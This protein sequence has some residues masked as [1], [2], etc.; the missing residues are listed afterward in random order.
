MLGVIEDAGRDADADAD[1]AGAERDPGPPWTRTPAGA[2]ASGLAASRFDRALCTCASAALLGNL[3]SSAAQ[4]GDASIGIGGALQAS[5]LAGPID[6]DLI[7]TGAAASVIAANAAEI[8][9]DLEVRGDLAATGTL[10]VSGDARFGGVLSGDGV[11]TVQGDLQRPA[12]HAA[13][14]D[15]LVQLEG[16]RVTRPTSSVPPC[17]CDEAGARSIREVVSAA[18]A[19]PDLGAFPPGALAAL[20]AG[21]RVAL[22]PGAVYVDEIF[23][24]GDLTFEVPSTT[25]LFVGGTVRVDGALRAELGSGAE[26]ELWIAGGYAVRGPIA[27]A[28]AERAHAARMLV[29]GAQQ[30]P[31]AP[32]APPGREIAESLPLP[33]ASE[34][35]TN[36]PDDTWVVHLYAPYVDFW[37]AR[38][39]NFYGA[40]FVQ[41]LSSHGDLRL[42]SDPQIASTSADCP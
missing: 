34:G 14:S 6:A 17:A 22:P 10:R 12:A 8:A 18:A 33:G 11:I 16:E 31:R 7:V 26:L 13:A 21:Q 27:L 15:E 4:G 1:A 24:E 9:G 41:S 35:P 20:T 38:D 30:G 42:Q 3:S 37:L 36:N 5:R 28:P 23:A 39:S 25:T 19:Q 29:A 2:A 40:L 32:N